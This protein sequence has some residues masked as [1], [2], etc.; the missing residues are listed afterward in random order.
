ML[1]SFIRLTV[2]DHSRL[3]YVERMQYTLV[4]LKNKHTPVGD[5]G[6]SYNPCR[7][8][9]SLMNHLMKLAP[10][11]L[12]LNSQLLSTCCLAHMPPASLLVTV[13]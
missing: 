13:F 12:P 10:A 4:G 8:R 11:S 6:H 3:E 1:C 2:S 9:Q 5:E 7:R